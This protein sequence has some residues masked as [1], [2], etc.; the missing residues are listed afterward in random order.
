MRGDLG[1]EGH[2]KAGVTASGYCGKQSC[3]HNHTD[4]KNKACSAQPSLSSISLL[5]S[6]ILKHLLYSFTCDTT[7]T[8]LPLALFLFLLIFSRGGKSELLWSIAASFLNKFSWNIAMPFNF[9]I[10]KTSSNSSMGEG[11]RQKWHS[12]SRH[13]CKC[14]ISDWTSN[15]NFQTSKPVKPRPGLE[16]LIL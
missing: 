14:E 13:E 5:L 2:C 15:H 6:F 16:P 9:I 3:I 1:W 4:N 11:D 12:T 7:V 8:C 10:E